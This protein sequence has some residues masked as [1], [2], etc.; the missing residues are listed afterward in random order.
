MIK[1]VQKLPLEE[2]EKKMILRLLNYSDYVIDG[3]KKKKKK[4]GGIKPVEPLD[5][6]KIKPVQPLGG[7]DEKE[8][9]SPI[10]ALIKGLKDY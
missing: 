6:S 4:S 2:D 8:G 10:R 9:L 1:N 3:P 5:P 7:E